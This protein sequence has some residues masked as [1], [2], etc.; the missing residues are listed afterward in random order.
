MEVSSQPA[1]APTA[2]IAGALSGS[3]GALRG[4]ARRRGGW[5]EARGHELVDGALGVAFDDGLK[6]GGEAGTDAEVHALPF[7]RAP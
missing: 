1:I 5:R 6:P 4:A 3:F 2:S 7:V